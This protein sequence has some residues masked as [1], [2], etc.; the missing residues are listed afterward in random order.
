MKA[1]LMAMILSAAIGVPA[2]SA[3]VSSNSTPPPTTTSTTIAAATT[4]TQ[5]IPTD[6]DL[7]T[8]C[9]KDGLVLTQKES[10]GQISVIEQ[11]ALDALRPICEA[12]GLPLPGSP[13]QE[14]APVIVQESSIEAAG[15]A[16]TQSPTSHEDENEHESREGD[17]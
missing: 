6:Q 17:D 15:S 11:A 1:K 10:T 3:L 4:T 5:A 14:T 2:A 13:Q 9:T 12:N 16:S 8:A 7:L